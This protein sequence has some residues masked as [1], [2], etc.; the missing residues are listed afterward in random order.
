MRHSFA[1]AACAA[2]LALSAP[3]LAEDAKPAGAATESMKADHMKSG[4][5]DSMKADAPKGDG[6][7]MKKDTG[8]AMMKK[9][10][11]STDSMSKH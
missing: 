10:P 4:Q 9:Q 7:M 2:F 1:T 6:A 3:A 5:T 8:G 11:G